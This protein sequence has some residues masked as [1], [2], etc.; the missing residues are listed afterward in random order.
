MAVTPNFIRR[1]KLDLVDTRS[2]RMRLHLRFWLQDVD[3]WLN[4]P[5]TIALILFVIGMIGLVVRW[6]LREVLT[7][8]FVDLDESIWLELS[9]GMAFLS[10]SVLLIGW[11]SEA[12]SRRQQRTSELVNLTALDADLAVETLA[13]LRVKGWLSDGTLADARLDHP[14]LPDTDFMTPI[15]EETT[16]GLTAIYLQPADLHGSRLRRADLRN[17]R[18]DGADLAGA[19]LRDSKLQGAS[20]QGADLRG[21]DLRGAD[22]TDATLDG[23]LVHDPDPTWST[24]TTMP[25]GRAWSG[26]PPEAAT[27]GQ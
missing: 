14:H 17:S 20:L 10:I 11:A 1:R 9:P 3:S 26:Q 6:V 4:L 8:E 16:E 24:D 21:T 23:A 2:E 5:R 15:I 27:S 18:L 13:R 7:S 22:L 19:D 25:D 12:V